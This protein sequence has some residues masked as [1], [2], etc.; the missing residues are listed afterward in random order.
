MIV[1]PE[2]RTLTSVAREN[3]A[4]FRATAGAKDLDADVQQWVLRSWARMPD[5]PFRM[6]LTSDLEEATVTIEGN[7]IWN[8]VKHPVR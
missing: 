2:D 6:I 1:W 3:I 5:P 7:G 4:R 8:L